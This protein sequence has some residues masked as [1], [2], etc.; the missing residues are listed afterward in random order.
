M[1]VS[2]QINEFLH[3]LF[4][5]IV[6]IFFI[7]LGAGVMMGEFFKSHRALCSEVRVTK[8][9][10]MRLIGYEFDTA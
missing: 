10:C 9:I 2:A 3:M 4:M 6:F 1:S 5:I 8:V 7:A